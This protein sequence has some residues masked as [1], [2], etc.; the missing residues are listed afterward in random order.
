MKP[1]FNKQI[2][3]LTQEQQISKMVETIA[4]YSHA[5]KITHHVH[6]EAPNSNSSESLDSGY[7]SDILLP[8]SSITTAYLTIT[9]IQSFLTPAVLE[10]CWAEKYTGKL[11]VC[12][13]LLRQF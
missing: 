1:T 2:I 13:L 5:P 11:P 6:T 4:A 10:G 7:E 3:Y 9:K 8:I 12:I